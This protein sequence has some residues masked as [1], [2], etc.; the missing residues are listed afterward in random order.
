MPFTIVSFFL[1]PKPCNRLSAL[2]FFLITISIIISLS[3]GAIFSLIFFWILLIVLLLY[4]KRYSL[5]RLA[6][7]C[8]IC[9]TIIALVCIPIRS[10][11]FTIFAMT[12]NTSQVRSIEGRMNKWNDAV[13]LFSQHFVTGVGAGNF[14]LRVEPLGNQRESASTGRSTNSWLQLAAE[15]G[16]TGLSAYGLFFAVWAIGML[17]VL[18]LREKHNL[19]AMICG[20]GII[21]C[22]L[23]ETTFSSLFDRP[24][25]L[26]LIILL[27]WFTEQNGKKIKIHKG[28]ITLL[29]IPIL[30]F[31]ILQT[32]QKSATRNNKAFVRAYERGEYNLEKL[33]KSLSLS[34]NNAILHANK[35]IYLLSKISGYDSLVFLNNIPDS[36]L[37]Q[38]KVAFKRAVELNPADAAFQSNLGILNLATGDTVNALQHFKQS[39]NL[40]PHQSIYHILCGIMCC[41]DSLYSHQRFVHA[42]YYSPDVLD[43]KWFAG[44]YEQDSIK[45]KYVVKDAQT[46]ICDSLVLRKNDYL[47]QSRLAKL[48][49]YQGKTDDA[50]NLLREVT[51]AM[52]NLNR[53]WLMLGDIASARNDTVALQ[54]YERAMQ[55]D[56]NDAWA[57]LRTGDW[58]LNKDDLSKSFGYYI[59]ALRSAYLTPT[60]HSRRTM[61]MYRTQTVSNDVIPTAF[62]WYIRPYLNTKKLAIVIAQ[63]YEQEGN[64]N[65]VTLYRKLANGEIGIREAVN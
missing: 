5:K 28:W 54:Y 38:A 55:L 34:S 60:E 13:L 17:R 4:F 29:V 40:A 16:M 59:D 1:L 11:L 6:L 18:R 53:P 9:F 43:S 58:H 47:L 41:D 45:A 63:G 37:S 52:P 44:L 7:G 36:T 42:L 27:L 65:G 2:A 23:R 62:Y 3:R 39:L 10:Q 21:A 57:K 49:L 30:Y 48:L 8:L 64:T 26:L 56:P 14:A 24:T 20:A 33:Q 12:K 31:G 15:K 22:F 46:M 25:L 19:A 35:G 61:S 32:Q 51:Q 50:E